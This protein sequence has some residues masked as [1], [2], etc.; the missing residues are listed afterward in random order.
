MTVCPQS[1]VPGRQPHR[2]AAAAH[3][4]DRGSGTPAGVK[5]VAKRPTI[6]VRCA[7]LA[8]LALA[9]LLAAGYT[10]EPIQALVLV[11]TDVPAD[12]PLTVRVA[13]RRGTAPPAQGPLR[14]GAPQ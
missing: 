9:A 7:R 1:A 4:Q 2:R 14:A 13:L 12:R 11:G 8:S 3:R 10:D 5:R 6:P